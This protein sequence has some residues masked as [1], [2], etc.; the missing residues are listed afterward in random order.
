MD[1]GPFVAVDK[2]RLF[3]LVSVLYSLRL[4]KE[5]LWHPIEPE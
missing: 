1:G 3:P 4:H 2:S 5:F